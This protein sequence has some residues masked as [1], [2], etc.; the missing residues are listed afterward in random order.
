[1]NSNYLKTLALLLFIV[2]TSIVIGLSYGNSNQ[3]TYL[4]HGLTQIKP[5]FLSSDWF[6]HSTHHYHD[7]FSYVLIFVNYLGLPIDISLTAIEVILRIIALVAIYKIISLTTNKYAFMSFVIVLFFVILEQTHSVANSRIFS[8]MLEPSSFGSS[9]SLVG[10][11]FFLRGHYFISGASI[12]VAGYMHTNFLILGFVYL[13]I[14]HVLLGVEDIMRR[15]AMQFGPMV[16]VLAMDLPFLSSMMSSENAEKA[17]YIF[18]FIRSPHHYVP[19]YYMVD[20]ILFA[21]WSIL[22]L[23]GLQLITIE[24]GL[25]RRLVGLYSALLSL[26]IISTLLTTAVFIPIV[27]KLFVWRMAPFS[28]LLSQMLFVAGIVSH[29]FSEKAESGVRLV[30]ILFLL[31]LGYLF[32]LRWYWYKYGL[33]SSKTLLL[34]GILCCCGVLFLR[35]YIAARINPVYLTKTAINVVCIGMLSLILAYEFR[36]PFYDRS[37]LL[38]GHPGKTESEL[39]QWV[40]TTD[41]S[42]IFLT[43]PGLDNF[44]L[45]GERAIIADWKSTPVD[46]NGLMEWYKRIQDIT[47][48]VDIKSSNDA[49]EAY[50]HTNIDR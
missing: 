34:A 50:L 1:M 28:V 25:K 42:A 33:S 27:S 41:E 26:V 36:S 48:L 3:N 15:V 21:G 16:F 17:T 32:I 43:P 4:I 8:T 31:L 23:A 37:T 13:G 20:F 11:L 7:K 14:A 39:Y 24:N 40:K 44:R 46:P 22:G 10:F 45:H 47:G 5:D 35:N 2:L 38:N 12:A 49:N 29:A 19:S 6:A 30:T 9:L 18:Q